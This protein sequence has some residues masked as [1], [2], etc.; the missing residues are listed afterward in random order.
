MLSL[1][2]TRTVKKT[3]K[4]KTKVPCFLSYAAKDFLLKYIRVESQGRFPL[5]LI[6]RLPNAQQAGEG[7]YAAQTSVKRE[8]ER[9]KEGE[10]QDEKQSARTD[11]VT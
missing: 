5:S 3:K 1:S 11:P 4:E 8:R 10:K 9:D 7:T 6:W 2:S